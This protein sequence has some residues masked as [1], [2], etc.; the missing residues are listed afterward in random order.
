MFDCHP[1]GVKIH[2][3][4]RWDTSSVMF[5]E[6]TGNSYGLSGFAT[7]YTLTQATQL[8]GDQSPTCAPVA[9]AYSPDLLIQ[10]HQLEN[11]GKMS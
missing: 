9:L 8:G 2:L 4:V 3:W 10:N 6:I 7:S 11:S 1:I 5:P